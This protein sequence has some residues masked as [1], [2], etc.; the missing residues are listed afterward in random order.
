M[1]KFK[2]KDNNKER[3]LEKENNKEMIAL[4]CAVGLPSLE[5]R[6]LEYFHKWS[7]PAGLTAICP[8]PPLHGQTQGLSGYR[9]SL[10]KSQE[11]VTSIQ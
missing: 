8:Y 9:Y 1:D 4:P 6:G 10:K 7:I 3:T 2:D 11:N 5:L